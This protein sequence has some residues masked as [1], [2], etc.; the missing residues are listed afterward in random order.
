MMVFHIVP[1]VLCLH[2]LPVHHWSHPLDH[3]ED[4]I[5]HQ[6]IY[7]VNKSLLEEV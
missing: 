6:S 3:S 1:C 7:I 4:T 5:G 2:I